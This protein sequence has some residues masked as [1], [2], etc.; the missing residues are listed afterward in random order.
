M[1]AT[2]LAAFTASLMLPFWQGYGWFTPTKALFALVIAIEMFSI[3]GFGGPVKTFD[4]PPAQDLLL[5]TASRTSQSRARLR[6]TASRRYTSATPEE[7]QQMMQRMDG[8]LSKIQ[9]DVSGKALDER[10]RGERDQF[11]RATLN[12]LASIL[13]LVSFLTAVRGEAAWPRME[14]VQF[15]LI[16]FVIARTGPRAFVLWREP[17]PRVAASEIELVPAAQKGA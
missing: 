14:A 15:L 13:L 12:R 9:S 7:Q 2:Y 1:I 6:L 5:V 11:A 3:L 10:E 17:D 8:V 16:F 4:D